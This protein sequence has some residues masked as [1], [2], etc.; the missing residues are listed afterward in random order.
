[1]LLH[2]QHVRNKGADDTRRVGEMIE[3]VAVEKRPVDDQRVEL[4]FRL[5]ETPRTT[6]VTAFHLTPVRYSGRGALRFIR[7]PKPTVEDGE[8]HWRVPADQ[9]EAAQGYLRQRVD[10]ANSARQWPDIAPRVR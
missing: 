7:L 6:W 2:G 1:V 9:L 3:V 4:V 10:H 8:V 5:S